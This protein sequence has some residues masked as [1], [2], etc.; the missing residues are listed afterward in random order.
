MLETK[1]IYVV[2]A[3]RGYREDI[4]YRVVVPPLA[5]IVDVLGKP[6]EIERE[7]DKVVSFNYEH[8]KVP[9]THYDD[10]IFGLSSMGFED[11][12]GLGEK[13]AEDIALT[14]DQYDSFRII[15]HH[16]DGF[17]YLTKSN[18]GTLK[19]N[20][21]AGL[22]RPLSSEEL[23]KVYETMLKG[24]TLPSVEDDETKTLSP[25]ELK[26][27]RESLNLPPN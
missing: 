23:E 22:Q 15:N 4:P 24:L 9:H 1:R 21:Y 10:G 20:L 14:V 6:Q 11:P 5:N 26:K 7:G 16:D 19:G 3:I 27:F 2:H 17:I 25:E 12:S 8:F 13:I 18:Q